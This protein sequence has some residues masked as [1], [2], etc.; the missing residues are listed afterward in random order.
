MEIKTTNIVTDIVKLNIEDEIFDL[1]KEVLAAISRNPTLKW[2]KFILTDDSPNA[3]NQ[4]IPKKEFANIVKTGIH[5]PIKMSQGYI[6]DG[7]EYAVPIGSITSLVERDHFVEGIAAL[8]GKEFPGE[9][10]L[11][12]EKAASDEK[13]QISWELLYK[14]SIENKEL[15]TEDFID[16]SLAAATV[17]GMP[18]YEGRTPIVLMASKKEGD[19]DYKIKTEEFDKMEEKIKELE[20]RIKE[21]EGEKGTLSDSLA[22]LK[23]EHDALKEQFDA[24]SVEKEELAN[25]KAEVE[26]EKNRVEKL[27][28]I[29]TLFSEAELELPTEYL[30]DEEKREK[31]LA[32]DLSQLEFL[33]HDLAIFTLSEASE[34][35]EEEDDKEEEAS[36]KKKHLGSKTTLNPKGD[37]AKKMTPSEIAKAMKEDLEE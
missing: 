4:R 2:I 9:V 12:E 13:P 15:G 23:K 27:E 34:E 21:L 18:A 25:F 11:L 10:K 37:R 7:H 36:K 29:K 28:S 24:L 26:A 17:V 31:L 5:M 30:D 6:R 33:M 8:W 16:T 35:E 22:S 1:P 14:D 20:L 3:N 19:A 32:M